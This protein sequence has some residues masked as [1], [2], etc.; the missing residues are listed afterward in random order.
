MYFSI[1][2]EQFSGYSVGLHQK[3]NDN[4]KKAELVELIVQANLALKMAINDHFVI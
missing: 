3:V 4:F 1:E 2:L